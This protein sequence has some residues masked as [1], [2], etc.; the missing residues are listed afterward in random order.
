MLEYCN[1]LL[2]QALNKKNTDKT[3]RI[4]L[5]LLIQVAQE[6]LINMNAINYNIIC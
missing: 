2:K 6:W 1:S 4:F 3:S 5:F